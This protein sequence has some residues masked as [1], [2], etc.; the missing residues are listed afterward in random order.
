MMNIPS[1]LAVLLKQFAALGAP[2][3]GLA[4]HVHC[5]TDSNGVVGNTQIPPGSTLTPAHRCALTKAFYK[6]L[7]VFYEFNDFYDPF[8]PINA[9]LLVVLKSSSQAAQRALNKLN[10]AQAEKMTPAKG[11]KR[12]KVTPPHQE[13]V[14]PVEALV[15]DTLMMAITE[16]RSVTPV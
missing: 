2:L 16:S 13:H 6:I 8:W 5:N 1:E 10:K 4:P 14:D 12:H 3:H 11:D 15:Q 9:F 7:K